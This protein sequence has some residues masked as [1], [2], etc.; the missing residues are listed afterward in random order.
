M[1]G[2]KTSGPDGL[3]IDIY[4]LFKTKLI[5]PLLDVCLESFQTGCLPVSCSALITL[6][7]KPGKVPTESGSYR[8]ISLLNS[9]AKIIAKA[10]AM[11]LEKVLPAII[12]G[13]QNGFVQKRQEFHK[14]EESA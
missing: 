10:K 5:A 14:C 2:G 6:I 8:P 13:D 1:K 11:R 12:H 3:P 9:D 4:K 7:L